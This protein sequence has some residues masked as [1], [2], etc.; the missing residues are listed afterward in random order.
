[1]F[2]KTVEDILCREDPVK[3]LIIRKTFRRYSRKACGS[4]FMSRRPVEGFLCLEG[5]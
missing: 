4:Y 2:K 1:M 5:L 3:V